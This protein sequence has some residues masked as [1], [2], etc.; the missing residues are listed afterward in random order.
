M[1][2]MA[3]NRPIRIAK[4]YINENYNTA[5]NLESVSSHIGFN[6]AYFSFLFKK[7]T[8]K[9]FMEYVMEVRIQYAK[10]FLIQTDDDLAEIAMKV[11]YMDLKYFSKLFKK[12]AGLNPSEFRKLYS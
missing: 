6:P 2:K 3:D 8:G 11:G 1:K 12:F 7:E 4:Q 5:L 9:N 10:Q